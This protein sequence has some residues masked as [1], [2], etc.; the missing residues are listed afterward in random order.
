VVA[1]ASCAGVTALH[2]TPLDPPPK[3][4]AF[5]LNDQYGRSYAFPGGTAALLYFGFTHCKD[6]C[7][8]TIA[9]LAKARARAGLDSKRLPIVMVT[10]DPARDSEAAFR[11]FFS[12]LGV[13]AYGLNARPA[14]LRAIY[15][16]YGVDVEPQKNDIG[17]TDAVYLVDASGRLR[18]VLSSDLPAPAIAEDLRAVVH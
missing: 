16:A 11:A 10:V 5:R 6:V 7:P 8:Q 12:R 3:A 13:D 14:K 15:R 4:Y 18:E 9:L 2:G 1:L 17:H